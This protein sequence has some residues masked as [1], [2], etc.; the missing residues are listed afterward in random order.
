MT[1]LL[2]MLV[3]T[4][5]LCSFRIGVAKRPRHYDAPDTISQWRRSLPSI[6]GGDR[7]FDGYDPNQYMTVGDLETRR[8]Y[9]AVPNGEDPFANVRS[10]KPRPVQEVVQ[11]F[12]SNLYKLSPTLF[13]GFLSSSALFVAWQIPALSPLLQR[14]F[15]LSRHNIRERRYHSILLSAVSHSSALHLLLNV[16]GCVN[17]GT[18]ARRNLAARG[19]PLWPFALGAAAT[20]SL[21]FLALSRHG[22]CIGLSG[23]AL[24]MM[25]LDARMNP[26]K[27]LGLVVYFVPIRM[28]SQYALSGLLAVSLFGVATGAGNVAHATHL[29]GLLF[30]CFYFELLTRGLLRRLNFWKLLLIYSKRK[31]PR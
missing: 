29:G 22:S 7:S 4:L 27:V 15:M 18:V 17:F 21:S 5:L 26:A 14:H 25:A 11:E 8:Y 6:R 31:A 10:R 12:F 19:L 24:A 16:Y 30:G 9:A 23:V 13:Y 3:H 1:L 20:G 28:M 2:V